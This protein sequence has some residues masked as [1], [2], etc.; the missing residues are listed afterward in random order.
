MAVLY[1]IAVFLAFG[2]WSEVTSWNAY[3]ERV[4]SQLAETA[5]AVGNHVD[6]V[7][8]VA[9]QPL[10]AL[11]L[12]LDR[13]R[14]TALGG[15]H[16]ISTMRTLAEQSR[17][18]RSLA[19]VRADGYLVESTLSPLSPGLNLGHRDY[20]E[21]HKTSP[22][23]EPH[24]GNPAF[25][26]VIRDWF[27]TISRRVN[28]P[29]G[30]F[31]GV[32][33][34]TVS[35]DHFAKFFD[36][37]A[38]GEGR[39]LL[40]IGTDGRVLLRLPVEASSSVV[41]LAQTKFFRERLVV[42]PFG[43]A[44][45]TSP[46]DGERRVGGY[47]RSAASGITSTVGVATSTLFADW[48][49]Q[50]A[51]RWAFA[52][53]AVMGAVFLGI[54]WQR[55]SWMRERSEAETAA[56]VAEFRVIANA[57]SDLIEKLDDAGTRE[58]VSP[59]ARDLLGREPEDLIGHPI[60][61]GY[62]PEA[63]TDWRAALSR[64]RG[65]SSVERL[66]FSKTAV[67]G[68]TIWLESLITKAADT[69]GMVVVTRNITGQ[70][71][72]QEKL[73]AQT[74]IDELTRVFNKRHFNAALQALT[75][76]ALAPGGRPFS[77]LIV[78]VDRFKM[79]N[80]TY[81]HVPGDACLRRIAT[82]IASAVRASQDVVAR[83]GGEEFALLLPDVGPE[84]AADIAEKVRAA[85]FDLGIEHRANVPWGRVT[86]SIGCATFDG[87]VLREANE[88]VVL[89]D[90]ALYRAKTEARNAVRVHEPVGGV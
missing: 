10:G 46:F 74:K 58:Y 59:S 31:A 49:R 34:A 12:D 38:L 19:F 86:V 36:G 33:L 40:L 17:F 28:R 65:G 85:V 37:Y 48:V 42:E 69:G 30:T 8:E 76:A 82:A 89:A 80:D 13:D 75:S 44:E 50:V 83:Y 1:G 66:I 23:L 79:F 25:G 45:Y 57:S 9:K 61:F 2:V 20:F 90:R 11:A 64:I 6:D 73:D 16:F 22:S 88:L 4:S 7:I 26:P 63:E 77:L 27:I 51:M 87:T 14:A 15:L 53:M 54:R 52:L 29:D 39:T 60:F 18:V 84:R 43:T 24:I 55:Q 81:G 68:G 32:L 72:L 62:G 70:K 71:M 5:R 35:I 67:D 47:F 3:R 21:H 78:D 56:R 41:S